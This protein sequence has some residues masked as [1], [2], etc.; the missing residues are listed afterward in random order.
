MKIS[1]LATLLIAATAHAAE[2]KQHVRKA[3]G[4]DV[5]EKLTE[6]IEVRED[7]CV[8]SVIFYNNVHLVLYVMCFISIISSIISLLTSMSYLS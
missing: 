4:D 6:A 7:N 5:A 2:T 1:A 3:Q 8:R